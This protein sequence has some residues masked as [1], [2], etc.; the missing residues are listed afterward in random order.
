M[1]GLFCRPQNARCVRGGDNNQLAG[2]KTKSC[3]TWPIK[4]PH[5]KR[6]KILTDP[7]PGL[8]RK[9]EPIEEGECKTR[10]GRRIGRVP[11]KHLMHGS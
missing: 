1:E 11:G 10:S 5:F 2:I 6:R 9:N 3:Q 7:Y 4:L 8:L